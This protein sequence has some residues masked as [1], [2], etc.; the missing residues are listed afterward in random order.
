MTDFLSSIF[1]KKSQT[2][3]DSN[4]VK[5]PWAP[6]IPDLENALNEGQ[7]NYNN[8][9]TLSP[10]QSSAMQQ[11]AS[12][13]GL[14]MSNPAYGA[15][16]NDATNILN[17]GDTPQLTTTP[18]IK[19][20]TVDYNMGTANP[21]SARATQGALDPTAAYKSLLS[22]QSNNPN[23]QAMAD[24]ATQAQK[25]TYQRQA[26]D[27]NT[28]LTQSVLPAIR[29]GAVSS[30]GY[31][32]S[33]QG[34]AEGLAASQVQKD[35]DRN[36]TDLSEA[37]AGNYANLAGQDYEAAQGRQATAADQLNTQAQQAKEFDATNSLQARE[38]NAAN[39]SSTQQFNANNANTQNEQQLQEAGLIPTI[40]GQGLNLQNNAATGQNQQYDNLQSVLGLP[41]QTAQT[42]YT[43]MVNPLTAIAGLG[44]QSDTSG[45]ST[46]TNR[47]SAFN[48]AQ[49]LAAMAAGG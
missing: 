15:A 6:A 33:R 5:N 41:A 27:A 14:N 32:G 23:I 49:M 3:T 19:A 44:G 42:A 24:A 13:L 26:D 18:G 21:A 30:G 28:N 1:G 9:S 25:Q 29:S 20:S 31:G 10:D 8:F 48:I 39:D 38:L 7:T 43:N 2:S 22:G 11:Q 12:V 35:N 17:G 34:I 46:T 45:L 4:T 37:N 47:D 36:A 16:S 40:L